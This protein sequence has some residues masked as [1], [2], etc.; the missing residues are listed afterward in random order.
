MKPQIKRKRGRP[1]IQDNYGERVKRPDDVSVCNKAE[2]GKAPRFILRLKRCWDTNT[3]LES[4]HASVWGSAGIFQT[5]DEAIAIAQI[6][7]FCSI[8]NGY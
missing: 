3:K 6:D 7:A 8:L 4:C 1:D 5:K 2:S